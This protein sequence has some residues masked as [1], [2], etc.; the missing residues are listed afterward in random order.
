MFFQDTLYKVEKQGEGRTTKLE[1]RT[2][3]EKLV[4]IFVQTL[5]NPIVGGIIR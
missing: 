2:L 4:S 1:R 3:K 5:G